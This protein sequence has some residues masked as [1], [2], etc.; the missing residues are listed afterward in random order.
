MPNKSNK[1]KRL[2]IFRFC[3]PFA[4]KILESEEHLYLCPI[5]GK[6]FPEASADNGELTLEDIPPRSMGGTGLLLTCKTC[7]SQA[8]YKIDAYIKNHLDLY[9]FNQMI[10]GKD[11]VN[12]KQFSC[13]L[14]IN[15][16]DFP[17]CISQKSG[18][19]E[20]QISGKANNPA[21]VKNLKDYLKLGVANNILDGSEIKLTKTV[22]CNSRLRKVALLKSGFLLLTAMLGYT[23]AFD[24]R[25]SIVR[26]Q[27]SYPE[28]NLLGSIFW[29]EQIKNQPFPKRRIILVST[30]LPLFLV[31]FDDNAVILPNLSSPTVLYEV[32]KTDW[33]EGVVNIT[34]KV[35]EWPKKALMKLDVQQ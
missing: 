16:E 19:I 9:D 33:K 35:Y 22:K 30:P 21:N 2:S 26:E 1:A 11:T 4:S 31:T 10:A 12:D 32:L 8:G 5:C 13:N 34:G 7:N 17:S 28:K 14:L 18:I 6:K 24:E 15:D 3:A 29:I 27:I 23:Y 20:I 25:L